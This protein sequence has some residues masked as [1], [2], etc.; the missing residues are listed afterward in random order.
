MKTR[1][2]KAVE[3]VNR[4]RSFGH[5]SLRN[6]YSNRDAG[7]NVR[8][9][10]GKPDFIIRDDKGREVDIPSVEID[11]LIMALQQM[12]YKKERLEAL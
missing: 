8:A 12:K 9:W 5:R 7:L 6:R 3:K 10:V 4:K 2:V 11:S 1:N